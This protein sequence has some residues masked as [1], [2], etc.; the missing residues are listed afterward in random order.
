MATDK[1]APPLREGGRVLVDQLVIQGVDRIY[2]VA[3]ESFLPILDALLDVPIQYV[4]CRQEGGAAMMAEAY[5]KLTGRPGVCI[6]TRGPGATNASAGVHIAHQDSTPMLLL[7]GQVARGALDREAFQEVDFRQMFA[8][9]CKWV[10][11]ID[12]ADRIPEYLGHAFH[13]A[14]AGR[15]GPVVLAL[16]EDVLAEM[17]AV[18]DG[19]P[20]RGAQPR[21]DEGQVRAAR[22]RLLAAERPLLVVGGGGWTAEASA[23]L[24][25]FAQAHQVPVVASFRCQD[26][27]DNDD[28]LYAGDLGLG[29]N[30]ALAERVRGADCLLVAGAR[31]GEASTRNYTLLEVPVPR[32]ALVHVHADSGE[33]GRV[34]HPE[35]AINAS[36][37][38]FFAAARALPPPATAPAWR[39]WSEAARAD[40]LAWT[41]PV[42]SPGPLQLA[43]VVS[44]LAGALGPEDI[45]T[46]GAGNYTVWVHRFYRYR[47]YRTQLA[48]TSG[49]MGYGFPAAVAASHLYPDRTVVCFAG[50]GCFLM[51]G[52]ELA[53]AVQQ[54]LTPITLVVNN[55]ALGTIRAHQERRYPGRVSGTALH[56]P[57][58]AALARAHGAHGERI[59]DTDQFPA[60][61]ARARAA[62]L[63]AVI[64]LVL[65]LQVLTPSATLD[66]IRAS[67]TQR[68]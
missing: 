40:Y 52:Q 23:D 46:N 38:S 61:F 45:V 30:P 26:F 5:G 19:L 67:A 20:A 14:T 64:E 29:P 58:F 32:Q 42:K 6:V 41:R 68:R 21:A 37:A 4:G 47:R 17:V 63:P 15:P 35:L 28:P 11:Q 51:H 48:P 59:T 66:Q 34:Y 8:P 24:R 57:D 1:S 16:P 60:A 12:R 53:T 22:E 54:G 55:G 10:A 25:A 65:D 36:A 49:S 18:R 62:R 3:G 50:D 43:E 2:G 9:L 33:L 31:L 27:L 56:N 39:P 44:W 13:V 7:I